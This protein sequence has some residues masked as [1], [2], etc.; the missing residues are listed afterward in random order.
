MG[1][2]DG[3]PSAG[4]EVRPIAFRVRT[5]HRCFPYCL[6]PSLVPLHSTRRHGDNTVEAKT[7]HSAYSEKHADA[8][9]LLLRVIRQAYGA[10][11]KK[12]QQLDH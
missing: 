2:N 6:R 8:F 12:K 7:K 10:V 11:L 1:R 4:L 3:L 5:G 9:D